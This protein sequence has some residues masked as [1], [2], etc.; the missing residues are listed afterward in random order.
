MGIADAEFMINGLRVVCA[1]TSANRL[2]NDSLHLT[3]ETIVYH[4]DGAE[5][6]GEGGAYFKTYFLDK[7]QFF[8]ELKQ[9]RSQFAHQLADQVQGVPRPPVELLMGAIANPED[10][11]K[12][13]RGVFHLNEGVEFTLIAQ[14]ICDQIEI[15][16]AADGSVLVQIQVLARRFIARTFPVPLQQHAVIGRDLIEKARALS[17]DKSLSGPDLFID[18]AAR[19]YQAASAAKEKS[20]L[21]IGSFRDDSIYRLRRVEGGLVKLGYAPIVISDFV[22]PVESLETKMLSFAMFSKFVLYESSV[23]SGAIDELKICKDN[24]IVTAALHEK[25]YNATSMQAHY[26]RDTTFIKFFEYETAT[27]EQVVASAVRWAESVIE[28]RASG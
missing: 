16:K 3:F 26:E 23:P 1:I 2:P 15:Q 22:R 4:G 20:V 14:G 5:T 17:G 13:V 24:G 28:K 19:A 27:I 6:H 11:S 10:P 18:E 7:Q 12:R 25:G 21:V 9:V 8:T